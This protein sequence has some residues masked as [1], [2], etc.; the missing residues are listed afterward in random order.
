MMPP[1]LIPFEGSTELA[2]LDT[3]LQGFPDEGGR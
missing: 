3:Q 1:A 2:K